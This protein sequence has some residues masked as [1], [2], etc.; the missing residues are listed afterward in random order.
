MTIA[1]KIVG[2]KKKIF[3]RTPSVVTNIATITSATWFDK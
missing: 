1:A 2:E 3:Q